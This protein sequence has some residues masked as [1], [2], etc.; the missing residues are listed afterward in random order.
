M[1][2]DILYFGGQW[3]IVSRTVYSAVR[4]IY[5]IRDCGAED[6]SG[7]NCPTTTGMFFSPKGVIDP[8]ISNEF[9]ISPL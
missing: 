3:R 7:T 1:W 9:N 8:L 6:F 5:L 4:S 2:N